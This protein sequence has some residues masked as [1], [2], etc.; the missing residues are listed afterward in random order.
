MT[1]NY[2][3]AT[4]LPFQDSPVFQRAGRALFWTDTSK[5]G[6]WQRRLD[7]CNDGVMGEMDA[8]YITHACNAYP[9]LVEALRMAHEAMG[10]CSGQSNWCAREVAAP[11]EIARAILA[12]LGEA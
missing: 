3:P 4:P 10:N 9:E 6:K 1:T 5:P 12:K 2:K 8:A 11:M 7:G